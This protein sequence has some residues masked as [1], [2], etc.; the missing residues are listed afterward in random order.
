VHEGSLK[1][2]LGKVRGVFGKDDERAV[3]EL[4]LEPLGLTHSRIEQSIPA[5][6]HRGSK[7]GDT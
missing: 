6:E 3:R 1:S 5:A 2:R 4:L 7:L